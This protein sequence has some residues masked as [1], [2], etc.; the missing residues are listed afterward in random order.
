VNNGDSKARESE[1]EERSILAVTAANHCNMAH[2]ATVDGR[3]SL[4]SSLVQ[5]SWLARSDFRHVAVLFD[6]HQHGFAQ[7]HSR[8]PAGKL[9]VTQSNQSFNLPTKHWHSHNNIVWT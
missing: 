5:V 3:E 2:G 6:R 9:I 4:L 8:N 1:R 7:V